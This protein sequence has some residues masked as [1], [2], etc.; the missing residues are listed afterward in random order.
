[1]RSFAFVEGSSAKFWEVHRDGTDL[2]VRWGRTGTT[3]Q[4]KVKTFDTGEAAAAQ[5]TK[6]IAEKLRKGYAEST[7][8]SA[9]AP[10]SQVAGAPDAPAADSPPVPK[11]RAA[12]EDTLVLPGAWLRYRCPRRGGA[13]VTAFV[14]DPRARER[15]AE[16]DSRRRPDQLEWILQSTSTDP[17]LAAAA[18]QWRAGAGD[19]PPAGAAVCAAVASSGGWGDAEQAAAYADVWIAERG[20]LFATRAAT[21][22]LMLIL[23]DDNLRGR[24]YAG[25]SDRP[26]IRYRR[27]GDTSYQRSVSGTA[28]ILLRV[29][30]ALAAASAEEHAAAV[31]ALTT[32]RNNG[33]YARTATSV[34]VPSAVEW[35]AADVADAVTAADEYRAGLLLFAAGTADQADALGAVA[36]AYGYLTSLALITTLMDGIGAQATG[37]LLHWFD[38]D[39]YGADTQRRLLSALAVL[40]GDAALRGLIERLDRKYVVAALLEAAQRFPARAMRL[41]AEATP[42]GQITEL[43]RS[44]VL[45]HPELA[46]RVAEQLTGSAAHRVAEIRAA[47]AAVVP[48]PRSAVPPVLADPPWLRR[49]RA[50][51]PA[52]VPLPACAD[53]PTISW[54]PDERQ[55]WL[56]HPVEPYADP[57]YTWDQLARRI[58]ANQARWWEYPTFFM[59]APEEL[60]RPV[61]PQWRV[62]ETWDARD[63]MHIA[64][65]R[66]EL[67]MLPQVTELARRNPADLGELLLPYASVE[68]ALLMAEWY[69]R[70]K[71]MRRTARAWLLRHPAAAARALVPAALAAA[72]VGRRHAEQ[73]LLL[74]HTSGHSDA[75]RAAALSYG[76][77]A[78]AAIDT[79]LSTDPLTMLPTRIPTAPGWAV[80]GLLPAVV[81]REGAG[82][83][84]PDAVSNLLTVLMLGKGD[85]PYAGLALVRESC[86]PDSLAEFGWSLFQ[87]WLTAGGNAKEN[88]VLPVLGLIGND[89]TVRRLTP[90]IL[91]W[92]GE[93]GHARS[94]AGVQVLAAI[95]TDVALM[96][97]HGIAQRAKFKGLKSAAEQQMAEVAAGLGLSAD[98]L[99]DRLVPDFGLGAEGSLQLDYGP[100]Q[101]TV[102][103]DEQLR[104]Y[105]CDSAGKRLKT[106]PKP[107]ARD[108]AEL[109][110]AAAKQF[111]ALKKDVRTVAADQLRRLER[112]MVTGRRW[113]GTEFRQLFVAHPLLWHIVRRLV[114][115]SY[116]ES[117][118]VIDTLRVAEDRTFSTVDDEQSDL[119]DD[120]VI[121]VAH[122][123]HLGETLAAWAEI[124]ADYEI[125]QPFPQLGRPTYTLTD[126]EIKAG[127]FTRFEGITVHTGKVIGLE[128]R[129][130]R[131]ESPQ[132]AGHQGSIELVLG[133]KLEV[134]ISLDP[135]IAIGALDIFP[136]QKLDQIFL[137]DGNGYWGKEHRLPLSRLDPVA[138]SEII[139]DLT[140]ITA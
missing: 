39:P 10:V 80:P 95:G 130:W 97:L 31:A 103:F 108:D 135:G 22:L 14:P 18:R 85:E 30:A 96:H 88:W 82:A 78:A 17:A 2:T 75:V 4:A 44:H 121:G 136:E 55:T 134:V 76:G 100:R 137:S 74:L 50:A 49:V 65:A 60:V 37:V 102:G 15:A 87:R 51:K 109:A 33:A 36:D 71:S 117:G 35:V 122:P 20:L 59:K 125:L 28:Y 67:G 68:A 126:E 79:L 38:A 90:M 81:L 91:A 138:V 21:E 19:A 139:R 105:V 93:G 72:G 116:D 29:R 53:A 70:L 132:D 54:L 113:S 115:A 57:Q 52:V 26:G 123:L 99:A 98:Q 11:P 106:L 63:W 124:F 64:V 9:P 13:G 12:N 42:K 46:E 58:C 48:A 120:A 140:E 43:L 101:F 86:E 16:L 127:R 3:G 1:M 27:A 118:T 5:E 45:T 6:L 128:R 23:T 8:T 110:P 66:F 133:P 112:A 40:P 129:G 89:E 114:W 7:A 47:A 34:L 104:P 56:D 69:G 73:A 111:A 119:A 24:T 62:A 77:E 131:R 83:L 41:L 61:L 25:G 92:P 84:P 32:Y 94:V 107:G